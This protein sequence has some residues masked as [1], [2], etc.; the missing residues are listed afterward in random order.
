MLEPPEHF[1]RHATIVGQ[2]RWVLRSD[3]CCVW[4]GRFLELS[5]PTSG[6][7]SDQ[8]RRFDGEDLDVDDLFND[9][10]SVTAADSVDARREWR[11][12]VIVITPLC[13]YK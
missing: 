9:G 3:E 11:K 7:P 13:I 4:N 2:I 8:T 1:E 10:P 6:R 5:Q 12:P